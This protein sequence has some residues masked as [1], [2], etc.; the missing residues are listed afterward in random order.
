MSRRAAVLGSPIGHS[1]SPLLHQTAY[2]DLGLDWRYEAV[3]VQPAELAQFIETCDSNWV[4]LSLTMPLKVEVLPLLDEISPIAMQAQAVNT[5][6]FR[7]G[8]RYGDNT[9]VPALTQ[10]IGHPGETATVLGAG[11]T[12][13]SAIIALSQRGIRTVTCWARRLPAAR[14][15]ARFAESHGIDAR[16]VDGAPS[17]TLLDASV[18]VS[19]LPGDA[20]APWATLVGSPP[21]LLIDVSYDPWPPPL[22]KV[23]PEAH[24]VTGLDV[25]A[26]QAAMQVEQWTG[27]PAPRD[28]MR[29]AL[30]STVVSDSLD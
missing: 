21:G 19:T 22:T 3:E 29:T 27:Q 10:L 23:W 1:R 30:L 18:V 9:D 4:G 2:R 14:D 7:D 25:L 26:E 5:V 12:A 13:R 16:A 28:A 11:A 15:L 17:S 6:T 20:A 8:R 24:C